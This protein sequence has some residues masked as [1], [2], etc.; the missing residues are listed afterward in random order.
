MEV[1]LKIFLSPKFTSCVAFVW[2]NAAPNLNLPLRPETTG[3]PSADGFPWLALWSHIPFLLNQ[4][5]PDFTAT[6]TV[7][8]VLVFPVFGKVDAPIFVSALSLPILILTFPSSCNITWG[9]PFGNNEPLLGDTP[10]ASVPTIP[11]PLKLD[12]N[13]LV[14]TFLNSQ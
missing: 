2:Y 8:L 6:P 14:P 13:E 5:L 11:Y 10:S 3:V 12:P 1:P 9:P 7:S 4:I